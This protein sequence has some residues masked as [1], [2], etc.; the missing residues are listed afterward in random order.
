MNGGWELSKDTGSN[1]GTEVSTEPDH[2][3]APS[4]VTTSE[5]YGAVY[6]ELKR[7]ARFHLSRESPFTD[8]QVTA[9]VHESYVRMAHLEM[10]ANRSAFFSYAARAM[11]SIIVDYVRT[12][13]TAKRNAIEVSLTLADDIVTADLDH[14]QIISVDR[15]LVQLEMIDKRAHDLVELRYFAGFTLDECAELLGISEAT[16]TRDWRKAR[17]LLS[18]MLEDAAI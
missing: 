11:R 8:L 10:P 1:T 17:A 16:A 18:A 2:P 9:L 14:S 12:R 3:R 4:S 15:A 13:Q 7:L 5:A 6:S